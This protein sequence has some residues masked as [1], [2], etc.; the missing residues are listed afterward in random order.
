MTTDPVTVE[1][2]DSLDTAWEEM[3]L[4]MIR[5]LPVVE[6]GKLVGVL[7]QRDLLAERADPGGDIRVR[8]LMHDDLVTVAP[9]LPAYEAAYLILRYA[10]GSV[11]VVDAS[12]ALVGIVTDTD[13]VRA[14]YTLLGGEVPVEDLLAEDNDSE[15]L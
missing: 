13:F 7:S 9:D 15:N 11:P 6:R 1:P 10:I 8:D 5:H 3:E 12:G 2:G 14:A 4:S